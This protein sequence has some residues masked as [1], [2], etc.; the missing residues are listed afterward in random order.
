[1]CVCVYVGAKKNI[2]VRQECHRLSTA[3]RSVSRKGR[4][5][6]EASQYLNASMTLKKTCSLCK[7]MCVCV[8]IMSLIATEMGVVWSDYK[9]RKASE[10]RRRE[11]EEDKDKEEEKRRWRG[12]RRR[13]RDKKRETRDERREKRGP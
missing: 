1:M 3:Y 8:C 9:K 6:E 13:T 11:E 5:E 10:E 12:V 2:R 4:E 7:C